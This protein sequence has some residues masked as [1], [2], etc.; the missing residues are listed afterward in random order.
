MLICTRTS[1]EL[2]RKGR[3]SSQTEQLV[4]HISKNFQQKFWTDRNPSC[5]PSYIP[6]ILIY[7]N[8]EA[9]VEITEKIYYKKTMSR[10]LQFRSFF[11]KSDFRPGILSTATPISNPNLFLPNS[12]GFGS[13]YQIASPPVHF[14]IQCNPT[15]TY[16]T[17]CYASCRFIFR[18]LHTTLTQLSTYFLFKNY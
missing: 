18:F 10:T 13:W 11:K 9:I 4:I 17:Q 8:E 7:V 5:T 12:P 15:I 1:D 6:T 16:S 2:K 3:D 14:K